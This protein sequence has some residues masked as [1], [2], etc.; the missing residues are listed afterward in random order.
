MAT[1]A[2][3]LLS[4]STD[5]QPIS[6]TATATAGTLIHTAI[7]GSSS[8]DEVYLWVSN[9][10]GSAV[11]LTIEWGGVADPSDLLVKAYSVGANSLPVPIAPG[12]RINNGS[13]IRAFA[14][15]TAVLNITGNVNRIT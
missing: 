2:A 1:Y 10:S 11:N 5:G 4:G 14:S 3:V 6:V 15:T 8:F 7:A 13:V 12:L 9:T